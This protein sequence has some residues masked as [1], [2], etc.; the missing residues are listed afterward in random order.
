MK[1]ILNVDDQVLVASMHGSGHRRAAEITRPGN[2]SNMYT[3]SAVGRTTGPSRATRLLGHTPR[4]IAFF[5]LRR[6]CSQASDAQGEQESGSVR[7]PGA[8]TASEGG[9]GTCECG[10]AEEGMH[11][12]MHGRVNMHTARW[13]GH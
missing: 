9:S 6:C 4:Q 12:Y 8:E 5:P 13:M 3:P 11:I 1:R 2:H 7:M 10:S